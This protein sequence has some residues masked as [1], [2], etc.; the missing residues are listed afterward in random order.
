M[1][2]RLVFGDVRFRARRRSTAECAG[3]THL[4]QSESP[5]SSSLGM[6]HELGDTPSLAPPKG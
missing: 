1:G 2:G 3:L 6:S 4:G 5:P